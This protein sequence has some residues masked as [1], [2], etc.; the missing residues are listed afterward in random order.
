MHLT[1]NQHP[2]WEWGCASPGMY[3]LTG[4][5]MRLTGYAHPGNVHSFSGWKP[6]GLKEVQIQAIAYKIRYGLY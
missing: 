6:D 4:S 1:G 2:H 5:G 3:I